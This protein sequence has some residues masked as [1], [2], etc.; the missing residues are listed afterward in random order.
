MILEFLK[1]MGLCDLYLSAIRCSRSQ[2]VTRAHFDQLRNS[3]EGM[4]SDHWKV[5]ELECTY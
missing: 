4:Y 3:R 2:P 1:R 5:P